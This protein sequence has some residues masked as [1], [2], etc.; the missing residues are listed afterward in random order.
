MSK[1]SCEELLDLSNKLENLYFGLI[2]LGDEDE[3]RTTLE[4][5]RKI[6][7]MFATM[8]G[9]TFINLIDD[10][11]S[12]SLMIRS[13][14]DHAIIGSAKIMEERLNKQKN[15]ALLN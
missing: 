12:L 10:P 7:Q 15:S 8:D 6:T 11:D 3:D 5:A 1:V 4:Y 13:I 9:T 14:I 2:K